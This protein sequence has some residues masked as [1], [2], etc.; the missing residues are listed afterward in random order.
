MSKTTVKIDGGENESVMYKIATFIVDKRNLFFLLFIFAI[1][2]SVFAQSWVSVEDDITQY[3]PET[4]ET[5]RGLTLMN[6]EF[7]TYGTASVMVSNITYDDA[8]K[9]ADELK[10]ISGV[11]GV[12]FDDTA[13]HYKNAAALFSITFDGEAD[14][15]VSID[16]MNAVSDKLNGYDLSVSSEVG[17][18]SSAQLAEEM[19]IVTMIAAVIIVLV[20]LFTSGSYAEI[21]VLIM[22][23]GAAAILNKG[24]NFMLGTISFISDSVTVVLQLA[25]AIDYAIILIHRYTEEHE[26]LP[27]REACI[28]ALSKAIP[29]ISS[30][31]LTTISGLGALAFMQFKIGADLAIVL[32]KAILLSLLSVFTLMP[33]LIMLF[34]NA[35]EKTKHRNFV[36]KIS[37][38]GRFAF[39]TRHVIPPVFVV[40]A[41]VAAVFA[42]RTPYC[43]GTTDLETPRQSETQIQEQKIKDNFGRTNL[44]ALVIPSGN[45]ENESELISVLE[46]YSE[47][48]SCMGLANIEAMDGYVLTDKLTPRQFAELVDLDY[49]VAMVAYGAYA[50]NDEN[51]GEVIN[52]LDQYGVPLI[53]MFMFVYDEVDKGLVTLDDEM[54]DTL[55][56]LHET[57][58]KAL[59]QLKTDDYTR[60]LVYLNLPEEGDE[61]FAF[62]NKIHE[63]AEKFYPAD[64]VYLVGNSTSDYDL[65]SSFVND[66]LLISILSALFVIII[67]LFTFKSAG[68]PVLLIAVIQGSIWMN[69]SVPAI[70][71][72]PLFFLSYLIVSSIQMGANIDYAIVISSRYMEL[73]KEMP[74]KKAITETL[75]QAFPTI[76]T[77]GAILA[78]AGILIGQIST[79]GT[80][81]SIGV[82]LGRGT[83][84]SIILVMGVLPQILIL[85]DI[86]IE[87]SSFTL[88][89]RERT[90][91]INSG[92]AVT[93]LVRGYVNGRIDA[94]V[95]GVIIGDIDARIE[96]KNITPVE[97]ETPPDESGGSVNDAITAEEVPA[98]E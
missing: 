1:I 73:K 80:I 89:K 21:P 18:D 58:N 62:L 19:N 94:V 26:H 36:P 48:D 6:D 24:T 51:Y 85:G 49:E 76:I 31:S 83:I 43:Y 98:H 88:K 37:A 53:D 23:F 7:V 67:L 60:I 9:L 50:V 68:L 81:S 22:T 59:L 32:I 64:E 95:N 69:F 97:G 90:Q 61:T 82:C 72:T 55:D 77:S 57:L 12:E 70:E 38:V 5:R 46:S 86:I 20:L 33:G 52:G 13:D 41:A 25:L 91:L 75:N 29:E 93:G 14:D 27:T 17:S 74:L 40:I 11:S 96:S 79:D 66:N 3:L 78:M 28:T 35:I 84:V 92:V 34:S 87:K 45:Y 16:A 8:E 15:Q 65:S 42:N 10:D 56:E 30:S 54:M 4:T 71:N 44:A 2:F 47:V 63:E 39:V